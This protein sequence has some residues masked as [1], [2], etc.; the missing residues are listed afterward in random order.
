MSTR[1]KNAQ[2]VIINPSTEETLQSLV[3]AFIAG[4]AGDATEATLADLR[5]NV[6][7]AVENPEIYTVLSRLKAIETL[8]TA[9]NTTL[10]DVATEATL[11]AVRDNIGEITDTPIENTVQDRLKN[12]TE[13]LQGLNTYQAIP[14][15]PEHYVFPLTQTPITLLAANVDRIGV[16]IHNNAAAMLYVKLGTGVSNASFTVGLEEGFFYEIPFRYTGVITGVWEK[17]A[18]G[19]AQ[20]TEYVV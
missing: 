6:G 15:T 7:L 4:D 9:S 19:D 20:V 5:N 13:L 14:T 8:I 17:N 2:G 12:I 3:D 10:D 18:T 16:S 1:I 11:D